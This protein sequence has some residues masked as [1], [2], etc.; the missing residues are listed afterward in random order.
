MDLSDGREQLPDEL[1]QEGLNIM[2]RIGAHIGSKGDPV[3]MNS[4][5]EPPSTFLLILISGFLVLIM[6]I[7]AAISNYNEIRTNWSHYRCMP[8]I[9]AFAKFYGYDFN[10]TMNFCVG[11]SVKANAPG[12]IDPIYRGINTITG[13]VD[14]VYNEVVGIGAGIGSLLK[15]F[16][17]FVVNFINSFRLLGTRVRMSVIRLKDIFGRLYG[18]FIS[19]ALAAI[20]AITFGENLICNPLV[21]FLGTI[22]GVDI[23]C[24]APETR[25]RMADGSA[26]PIS[27]IVIGDHLASG[28]TV[29]S[30]YRFDGAGVPMVYLNGVHVSTNH[31]LQGSKVGE[32]PEALEGEQL[33]RLW[34]LGTSNNIIPIVT[35]IGDM[36]FADYEES[37]DPAVIA[38]A[39]RIA[40][41]ALNAVQGPIVPDYSLGLDPTLLVLMKHGAWK[42]LQHVQIG[43][44]LVGGAKVTGL[45]EEVCAHQCKSPA[46]HYVSAAQLIRHEGRWVRAANVWPTVKAQYNILYHLMTSNG[47]SITVGGDGEV[48]IVRDYAEIASMDIQAPYDKKVTELRACSEAVRC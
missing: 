15:G 24:F 31:Y 4:F 32:H 14:G 35:E 34:C 6:Y 8:Q 41:K 28:A 40:E 45:I 17:D 11:E 20:S 5:K 37:S 9:T 42:S 21:V 27:A 22:S 10:E 2:K 18:I 26:K 3:V 36:D 46:G 29:C 19:F 23:C 38:E 44:E 7:I 12:V 47:D 25:I 1:E 16:N 13:V 48:F 43:E 39:Q 33:S 30:T